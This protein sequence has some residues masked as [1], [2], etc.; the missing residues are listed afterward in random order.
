MADAVEI[1]AVGVLAR[2]VADERAGRGIAAQIDAHPHQ[3]LA[4][5][6]AA[7]VAQDELALLVQALQFGD[8]EL[9]RAAAEP[10]LVEARAGAHDDA[11]RARRDL[12]IERAIVAALN[13][14]ER[15][16]AVGHQPRQD[17]EPPGRA[18]GIGEAGDAARGR[19]RQ[20]LHQRH[21]IDAAF[22]Q[23]RAL[24]EVDGVAVELVDPLQDGGVAAR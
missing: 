21:D 3:L 4:D 20:M 11:E 9:R 15:L 8:G 18:L 24:A 19:Q 23:H 2:A 14:V 5:V 12:D 6:G 7:L 17:V 10:H 22:L 1:D 13:L 16:A